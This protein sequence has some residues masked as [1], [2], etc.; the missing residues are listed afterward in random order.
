MTDMCIALSLYEMQ[1]AISISAE[2]QF[3]TLRRLG[4]PFHGPASV[5]WGSEELQLSA[6]AN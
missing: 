2:W 3:V 1:Q 5:P 4:R 6:G